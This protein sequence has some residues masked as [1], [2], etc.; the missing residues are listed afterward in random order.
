MSN[1]FTD[2]KFEENVLISEIEEKLVISTYE[3]IANQFSSTRHHMWKGVKQFLSELDDNFLIA[4]IGCGN[5]KNM[6]KSNMIGFDT[7]LEFIRICREKNLD[8]RYGDV[9]DIPIDS[10]QFDSTICVAVIHHLFTVERR[11]KAIS[12]LKRI[13]K[14][15]GKILITVWKYEDNDISNKRTERKYQDQQDCDVSFTLNNGDKF[16]RYY[17][18]FCREEIEKLCLQNDLKILQICEECGNWNLICEV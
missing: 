13:T 12:E 8:V 11:L 15:G 14:K 18:L 7:C 10:D 4:D 1:Q 2:D 16:D 17:H 6:T 3:K 9:T 5:G